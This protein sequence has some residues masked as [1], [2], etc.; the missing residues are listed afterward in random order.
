[1]IMKVFPEKLKAIYSSVIKFLLVFFVSIVVSASEVDTTS[2]FLQPIDSPELTVARVS[3]FT[4]LD[5]GNSKGLFSYAQSFDKF[6]TY[7]IK[8]IS[9]RSG[10]RVDLQEAL[11]PLVLTVSEGYCGDYMEQADMTDFTWD[12]TRLT[13]IASNALSAKSAAWQNTYANESLELPISLKFNHS[14]SLMVGF[15]NESAMKVSGNYTSGNEYKFQTDGTWLYIRSAPDSYV[16]SWILGSL[17]GITIEDAGDGTATVKWYVNDVLKYTSTGNPLENYVLQF[18]HNTGTLTNI[19]LTSPSLSYPVWE[20]SGNISDPNGDNAPYE[21]YDSTNDVVVG[22]VIPDVSGNFTTNY[23]VSEALDLS[24][25]NFLVRSVNNPNNIFSNQVIQVINDCVLPIVN[26]NLAFTIIQDAIIGASVGVVTGVAD[27]GDDTELTNW[28]IESGNENGAY[29]INP[30]TGEITVAD[31][32]QLSYLPTPFNDLYITVSEKG[33]VSEPAIVVVTVISPDF[34]GDGVNDLVDIDDDNDGILDAVESPDC[35]YTKNEL[36]E[37]T[38]TGTDLDW[39]S[40]SPLSNSIDINKNSFTQTSPISQNLTNKTIVEYSLASFLQIEN[41]TL[42][43]SYLSLYSTS[44]TFELQGFDGTVWVSLSAAII[45]NGTGV[46]KLVLSNTLAPDIRFSKLRIYGIQGKDNRFRLHNAVVNLI[47]V[48]PSQHPKA[49]CL[50]DNHQNLDSDGDGCSDAFEA[51]TT[52]DKTGDFAFIS[53]AGTATDVN[54]DGLAD[55]VDTSIVL[56][57]PLATSSVLIRCA[58]MDNDGVGAIADIDD[59]N[60]GILDAVESPA[61]YYTEREAKKIVKGYTDLLVDDPIALLH[62]NLWVATFNFKD[63]R[64]IAG[65]VI[66]GFETASNFELAS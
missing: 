13:N 44:G 1:M 23:Q 33:V 32:S 54:S 2:S 43:V 11:L 21:L 20:I 61:C 40:G 50:Q 8:T 64:P 51:G 38:I 24:S 16:S 25:A 47:N 60:D 58:D 27:D 49:I 29:T 35:Y 15:K 42:K 36:Y 7:T 41:L 37:L 34:D 48:I 59:D 39:A 12:N 5:A 10:S 6:H 9:E 31:P 57:Y 56:N 28:A 52:T 22:T 46:H 66:Y 4:F 18:N 3:V 53:L 17:G 14:A 26:S 19:V 45:D 65:K 55:A 30:L 62:D 63:N